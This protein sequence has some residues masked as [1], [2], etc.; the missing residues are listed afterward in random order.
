MK[1]KIIV[2]WK[3]CKNWN[4]KL[5]SLG[6]KVSIARWVT[7]PGKYLPKNRHYAYRNFIA[8]AEK[9]ENII[10]KSNGIIYRSYMSTDDMVF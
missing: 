10:V 6:L 5:G 7:F 1:N 8:N 2:A 9:G 4:K 3:I